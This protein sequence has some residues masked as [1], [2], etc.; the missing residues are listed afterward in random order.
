VRIKSAPQASYFTNTARHSREKKKKERI[1]NPPQASYFQERRGTREKGKTGA[2]QKK[3][4][5]ERI[6]KLSQAS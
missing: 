2:E 3:K 6:K 5:K 4:K 1:R